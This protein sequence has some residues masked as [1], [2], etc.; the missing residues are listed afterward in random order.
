MNRNWA[1][2]VATSR[3]GLGKR[4]W[5]CCP[6]CTKL[7]TRVVFVHQQPRGRMA[8]FTSAVISNGFPCSDGSGFAIVAIFQF[9]NSFKWVMQRWAAPCG[10]W[11]TLQNNFIYREETPLGHRCF[12]FTRS[13]F[14]IEWKLLLLHNILIRGTGFCAQSFWK[15]P[16][17][18]LTE[19]FSCRKQV[20]NWKIMNSMPALDLIGTR[21][22]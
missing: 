18:Y 4:P 15:S 20:Y 16:Q 7:S 1:S 11:P 19:F 13:A 2:G 9:G 22:V 12:G 8:M 10:A 17:I 6:I 3:P 14:R 21:S 5:S